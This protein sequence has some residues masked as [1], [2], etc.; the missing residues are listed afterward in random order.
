M[1]LLRKIFGENSPYKNTKVVLLFGNQ[2]EQDILFKEEFE[3]YEKKYPDRFKIVNV[4]TN[5]SPSWT[6]PK[7]YISEEL[8]KQNF[9]DPAVESSIVFVCGPPPLMEAISG[10]KNPDKSQG[11]LRGH[12]KR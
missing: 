4:I 1:Q 7:G 6:G 11:A 10:D 12:L 3:A 8:I 5:P 2:E 9:H